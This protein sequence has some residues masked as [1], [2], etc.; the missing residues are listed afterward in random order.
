MGIPERHELP[1][2]LLRSQLLLDDIRV[3]AHVVEFSYIIESYLAILVNI[4]FVIGLSDHANS[5]RAQIT[6][7]NADEFIKGHTAATI[8]IK[9]S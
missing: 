3:H 9:F 1:V 5:S 2:G 6:S 7:K 8:T 4:Q